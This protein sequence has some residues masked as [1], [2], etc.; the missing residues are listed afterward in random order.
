MRSFMIFLGLLIASPALASSD[1]IVTFCKTQPEPRACIRDFIDSQWT[2]QQEA[3]AKWEQ[4]QD[5]IRQENAQLHLE[6]ARLQANGLALFGSG[7]AM[8]NGVNQG[9][10]NMQLPYVNTPAFSYQD[11]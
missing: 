8:I 10:Q 3:Q 9:F 11:R 2:I 4:R 7:A 1:L 6:H 5:R